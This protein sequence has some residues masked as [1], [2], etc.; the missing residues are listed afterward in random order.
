MAIDRQTAAAAEQNDVVERRSAGR[1]AALI[2]LSR[3]HDAVLSL[4]QPALGAVLA[5]GGV[6]GLRVSLVG[7]AAAIC[8]FLAVFA[9][10]GL[11]DR[12]FERAPGTPAGIAR[13]VPRRPRAVAERRRPLASAAP[14]PR[15]VIV[16]VVSLGVLCG[17]LTATLSPLCLAFV[18]VAV[19]LD[20]V[21]CALRAVTAWKTLVAGIAVGLVGLAGWTAAAPLSWRALTVF[22][23]LALWEIGGRDIARDLVDV[24]ADRR[25]GATTVATVYGT[26]SAARA[27]CVLGFATLGATITLPMPGG[28]LNDLALGTGILLVAWPGAKLWHEPT[29]AEAASYVDWVRLY[30]A[31]VLAVALLP[32]LAGAL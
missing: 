27:A 14:G 18:C 1:F 17:V 4:A 22:G 8:G 30:P 16:W 12:R 6:P 3:G 19:A 32:A 10:N 23:F 2:D 5:V 28:M 31:A 13:G 20:V 21:Y 9:L 26:A 25:R 24:D 7:L 29:S 15:L 11:L